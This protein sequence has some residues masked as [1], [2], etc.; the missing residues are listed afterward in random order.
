M[1]STR[2]F[3]DAPSFLKVSQPLSQ[4]QQIGKQ[5]CLPPVSFKISL[6]VLSL[7]R[8]LTMCGKK[9]SIY[10]VHIRKCIKSTHFYSYPSSQL[11]TPEKSQIWGIEDMEFPGVS[12]KQTVE[13]PRVNNQSY[14]QSYTEKDFFLL[15]TFKE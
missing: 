1:N 12:K 10:G 4:N 5:C 13:F 7:S 14:N 6:R 2:L 3:S 8:M 15:E 9:F 11:K